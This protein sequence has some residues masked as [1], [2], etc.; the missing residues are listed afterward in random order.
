MRP[1]SALARSAGP[2]LRFRIRMRFRIRVRF[3]MRMR[4]RG[5]FRL[6]GRAVQLEQV[7][8]EAKQGPLVAGFR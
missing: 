8:R 4:V 7:V 2:G 6:R 1:C 5:D 3:R